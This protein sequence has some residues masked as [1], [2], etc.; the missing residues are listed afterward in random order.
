MASFNKT[1]SGK[2]IILISVLILVLLVT[3]ALSINAFNTV[4]EKDKI[5]GV[6][7]NLL[8]SYK[9]FQEFHKNKEFENVDQ[10]NL[11]YLI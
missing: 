4:K 1:I 11:P 8:Q 5:A 2:L 6:L 9:S 7:T 3:I 10:F